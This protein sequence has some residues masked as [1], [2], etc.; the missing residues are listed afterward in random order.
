MPVA[1]GV[2]VITVMDKF[3]VYSML[4][5]TYYSQNY[6]VDALLHRQ[7][8]DNMQ[9]D[10][11]LFNQY[12]SLNINTRNGSSLIFENIEYQWALPWYMPHY[13][14]L[15]PSTSAILQFTKKDYLMLFVG[16]VSMATI[17]SLVHNFVSS[18]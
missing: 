14:L 3:P 12:A 15:A 10:C 4:Q 18:A 9:K 16:Q 2:A 13:P 6:L 17:L 8:T 5:W 1:L 11:T 7:T